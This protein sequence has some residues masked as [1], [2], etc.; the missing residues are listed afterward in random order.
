MRARDGWVAHSSRHLDKW[1]V[2][3][4][5]PLV[6]RVLRD[7][8]SSRARLPSRRGRRREGAPARGSREGVPRVDRRLRGLE[9]RPL[10]RLHPTCLPRAPLGR[11]RGGRSRRSGRCRRASSL[12][13]VVRRQR[14]RRRRL[15]GFLRS[16]CGALRPRGVRRTPTPVPASMSPFLTLTFNVGFFSTVILGVLGVRKA[17]RFFASIPDLPEEERLRRMADFCAAQMTRACATCPRDPPGKKNSRDWRRYERI[18]RDR[19]KSSRRRSSAESSGTDAYGGWTRRARRCVRRGFLDPRRTGRGPGQ[20]QGPGPVSGLAPRPIPR[21]P[22]V[23]R[24]RP[25]W[26]TN[27]RV[28]SR[29]RR[30]ARGRGRRRRRRR[31][32]PGRRRGDGS[33][34]RTTSRA[35]WRK[36]RLGTPI[37]RASP[38]PRRTGIPWRR[39]RRPRTRGKGRPRRARRDARGGPSTR[40]EVPESPRVGVRRRTRAHA[41]CRVRARAR[42]HAFCRVRARAQAHAFCRV[43]ALVCGHLVVLVAG[44]G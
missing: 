34:R 31:T 26:R 42:A 6:V 32:R 3:D 29:R 27:A 7:A 33:R 28:D 40:T 8:A 4:G 23:Y 1:D 14:R 35:P 19:E 9:R 44:K 38:T 12:R 18:S 13:V 5:D 36:R 43:R 25:P 20:G 2:V 17:A 16:R 10:C 37:W 22:W 24:T 39:R 30:R 15:F 11:R 21:T 41:S